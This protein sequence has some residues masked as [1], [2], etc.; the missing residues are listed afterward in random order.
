MTS[1]EAAAYIGVS[2]NTLRKYVHEEGLPVLK[3]PGRRKWVFRKDLIDG[4]MLERSQPQIYV[5][6]KPVK[7][8]DYGKLR[9]LM[10]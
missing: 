8:K 6:D 9:V 1:K 4:W 5:N 3:F 7:G 2:I 10:P